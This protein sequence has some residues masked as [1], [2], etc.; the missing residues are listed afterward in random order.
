[1]PMNL[2]ERLES[3]A[4]DVFGDD[5]IVLTDDTTAEDIPEWDSLGHVNFV[6]SVEQ[7]FG[8]Q[9]PADEFAELSD[10]GALKRELARRGIE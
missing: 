7:E 8:V 10:I 1:M 4:R 5:D 3:I 6:Y 2:H 9:F